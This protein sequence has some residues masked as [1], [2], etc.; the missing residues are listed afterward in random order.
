MPARLVL[1]QLG[2]HAGLT[3][4][5]V[6]LMLRMGTSCN[7]ALQRDN[8]EL[9]DF[10]LQLASCLGFSRWQYFVTLVVSICAKMD[11]LPLRVHGLYF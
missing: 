1:Q 5:L 7:A 3:S 11:W 9:T 6:A 8:L 2:K 10:K 4:P